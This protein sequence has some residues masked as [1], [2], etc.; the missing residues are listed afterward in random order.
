MAFT[1]GTTKNCTTADGTAG[2]VYQIRFGYE[3][4][5]QDDINNQSVVKLRLQIRSTSSQY[6]PYGYSYTATI[7]GTTN[8]GTYDLRSTNTWI[9]LGERTVTVTHNSDGTYNVSKTG[10]F[11]ASVTGAR[12]KSGSASVSVS[13]PTIAR[14]STIGVANADIGASTTITI[15]R[16]NDNFTTTLSYKASG[17][18]SWT[19]IVSKTN[20][21]VYPWTVPSS[22]YTLIPNAKNISCEFKAETF[23]GDTSIGTTTTT[24]TFTATGNPTVDTKT[25]TD[26]NSITA[27]LTSGTSTSTTKMVKYGSNVQINVTASAINSAYISSI[28]VNGVAL[29]LGGTSTSTTRSGSI[30]INGATTNVFTIVATDTRGNSTT[31]TTNTLQIINYIPLTITASV[32]RN[33]PVDGKV[34]ISFSGNY[35]SGNFGN[36]NNTLTIQYRCKEDGGNYGSWIDITSQATISNNTYSGTKQV[37]DI[38]YTKVYYFDVRAIDKIYTPDGKAATNIQVTKGKPI[39]YWDDNEFGTNVPTWFLRDILLSTI[40]SSTD[41]SSDIVYTYGNSTEKARLYIDNVPTSSQPRLIYRAKDKNDELLISGRMM[42]T[43]DMM[44]EKHDV[45]VTVP[46][47]SLNK[48]DMDTVT[49]PN[50]YTLIG[51]IPRLNGYGDQWL[52]SLSYYSN[53]VVAMIQSKYSGSLTNTI[54]YYLLFVRT[55]WFPS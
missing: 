4:Q 45:S 1:Y 41:D 23:N 46:A 53:K 26:V 32:R 44:L 39:F 50:G 11:S 55:N 52:V 47:N 30:T 5:S 49:I 20:L 38:D 27:N 35:W 7:E 16:T 54:S 43:N 37:S 25:A 19:Q 17:Q 14:A 8:S 12:P 34:N 24:A 40:D 31:T 36:S 28:T 42:L 2:S 29:T 51:V 33:T 18:N 22:F 6:K 15:A 13:L 48:Y 9:T 3:L 10:S 21:Q